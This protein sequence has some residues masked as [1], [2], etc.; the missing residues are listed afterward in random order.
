MSHNCRGVPGLKVFQSQTSFLGKQTSFQATFAFALSS[1]PPFQ[2]N[3]LKTWLISLRTFLGRIK[4]L[5][6]YTW[7]LK[8]TE[9]SNCNRPA[10]ESFLE[11][12]ELILPVILSTR[13]LQSPADSFEEIRGI[14]RYLTG[15]R[16][17]FICRSSSK[18]ALIPSETPAQNRKLLEGFAFKPKICSNSSSA[19]LMTAIEFVKTIWRHYFIGERYGIYSDNKAF[20]ISSLKKTTEYETKNGYELIK[21]NDCEILY[22]ANIVV[23]VRVE[24]EINWRLRR[25]GNFLSHIWLW[26]LRS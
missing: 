14:P 21:D 19:F 8:S 12:Q 13:A 25:I 11:V 7:R 4:I 22:Q 1:T 23:D 15:R 26:S 9:D 6:Q 17:S 3:R 24:P 5:D 10:K 2:R 16:P 18:S 20:S